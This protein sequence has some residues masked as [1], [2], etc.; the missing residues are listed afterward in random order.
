MQVHSIKLFWEPTYFILTMDHCF[1][2]YFCVLIKSILISNSNIPTE[3]K[4]SVE[5]AR[6]QNYNIPTQ[7][8][9]LFSA[10]HLRQASI[11][12]T[13]QMA[14]VSHSTSQLHMATAFHFLRENILS[15]PD[16]EP[17]LPEWEARA[18]VSSP[19]STSAMAAPRSRR[20][21]RW[22]GEEPLLF[23]VVSVAWSKALR[24]CLWLVFS[25]QLALRSG[26]G[27][28]WFFWPYSG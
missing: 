3:R 7:S 28:A 23:N 10:W 20:R 11:T 25:F 26:P 4:P 12:W 13:L 24:L 21:R 17:E 2:V 1:T 15:P 19:S 9:C 18:Q 5:K 8:S 27:P 22:L 14:H 16:L 6:E